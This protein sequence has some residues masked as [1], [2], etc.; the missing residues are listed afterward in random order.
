M[1]IE[2]AFILKIRTLESLETMENSQLLK[3]VHQTSVAKKC[4]TEKWKKKC[5]T[6]QASY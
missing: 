3:Q 5:K 6:Q 1:K 2:E 4:K